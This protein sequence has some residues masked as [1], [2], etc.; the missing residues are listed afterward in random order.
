MDLETAELVKL[1]ANAFLAAKISFINAIAEVCEKVGA[2]VVRLAEAMAYDARIGRRFLGPGLGFGGG[3]LP[4]DIRAFRASAEELGVDSLA[5][6][7]GLVDTINL[8]RR[9]RV[10][11]L[12]REAAGGTLA[13]H[14]IGVLGLSFKPG[15]DD[16]R[17]SPSLHVCDELRREGAVVTVHDPVAM[18]NPPGSTLTCDTPPLRRRRPRAPRLS[19]ISPS[20]TTTASS[21]QPCWPPWSPART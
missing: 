8:G 21:I 4:K 17:D 10:V 5:S 19:C 7:L 3:C 9:S 1:S 6:I 16:I 15:S 18:D 12:A 20:G 2:D 13:G 14:H 11:G